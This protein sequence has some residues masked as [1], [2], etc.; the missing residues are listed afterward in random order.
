MRKYVNQLSPG[1][2][3]AVLG[4]AEM[5]YK[6]ELNQ[7]LLMMREILWSTAAYATWRKLFEMIT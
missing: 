3:A 7:D 4:K 1:E 2:Q 5:Y 6:T